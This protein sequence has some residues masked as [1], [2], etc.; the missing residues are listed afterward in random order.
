MSL[1]GWL[2]SSKKEGSSQQPTWNP[3]TMVMN[4]PSSPSAPATERV[5]AQQPVCLLWYISTYEL[6]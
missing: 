6:I 4:Q 3:N 5:V 1:F 2:K